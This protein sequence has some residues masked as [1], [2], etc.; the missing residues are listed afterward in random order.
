M[1]TRSTILFIKG[2]HIYHE[3]N[4]DEICMAIEGED[5]LGLKKNEKY[6]DIVLDLHDLREIKELIEN[7]LEYS[8]ISPS[9]I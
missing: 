4:D 5:T 8:S 7:Y 1:S 3:M 6:D 9:G 2:L